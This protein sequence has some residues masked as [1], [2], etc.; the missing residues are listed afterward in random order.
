M[1]KLVMT[2][3]L[4]S[5][6]GTISLQKKGLVFVDADCQEI[7]P[8]KITWNG[9]GDKASHGLARERLNGIEKVLLLADHLGFAAGRHAMF[10]VL[11]KVLD[12]FDLVREL[13]T[14]N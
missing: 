3:V 11:Q 5:Y 2:N 6:C 8:R 1:E 13:K 10:D 4:E 7:L 9:C 12:R 14:L